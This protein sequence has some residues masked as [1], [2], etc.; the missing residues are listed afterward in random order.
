VP[1]PDLAARPES[2]PPEASAQTDDSVKPGQLDQM[3]ASGA[4]TDDEYEAAKAKLQH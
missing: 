1:E 3:K 2:A 4:L